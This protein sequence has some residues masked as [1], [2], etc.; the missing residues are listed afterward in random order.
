MLFRKN[1]SGRGAAR[2]QGDKPA[3]VTVLRDA[4]GGG[5]IATERGSAVLLDFRDLVA[6]ARARN[7]AGVCLFVLERPGALAAFDAC[8]LAAKAW[9]YGRAEAIYLE[10]FV[11]ARGRPAE[12]RVELD[13]RGALA[14]AAR[15]VAAWGLRPGAA[16]ACPE[17]WGAGR[18]V[19]ALALGPRGE[20]LK[21]GEASPGPAPVAF[22]GPVEGAA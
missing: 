11:G 3:Q 17:L 1:R 6:D 18:P 14:R 13:R 12:L 2:P 10:P 16:V 20:P 9:G 21:P 8:A 22:F 15:I 4:R 5:R 7:A 19:G